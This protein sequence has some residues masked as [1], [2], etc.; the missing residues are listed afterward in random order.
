[1]LDYARAY[2]RKLGTVEGGMIIA[3]EALRFGDTARAIQVLGKMITLSSQSIT[4]EDVQKIKEETNGP[5][6]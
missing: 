1:M 4:T 2:A 3:L 6:R 5:A